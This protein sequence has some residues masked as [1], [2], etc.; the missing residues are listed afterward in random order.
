MQEV[1]ALIVFAGF[2]VLYLKEPIGWGRRI[3]VDRA[4][5]ILHFP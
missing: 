5:S 1:V 3:C 2:S 4:R